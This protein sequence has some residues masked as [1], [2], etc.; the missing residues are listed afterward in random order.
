MLLMCGDT[1]ITEILKIQNCSYGTYSLDFKDD[2][3][4]KKYKD[5]LENSECDISILK[6]S[7]KYGIT[8]EEVCND[9]ILFSWKDEN[10]FEI[11]EE[12]YLNNTRYNVSVK[13]STTTKNIKLPVK[14][15]INSFNGRYFL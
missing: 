15:K 11:S 4:V 13:K 9:E 3:N 1:N 14:M 12:E 2:K 7:K 6:D 5:K 8:I 10:P